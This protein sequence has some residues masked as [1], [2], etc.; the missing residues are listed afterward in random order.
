MI[1]SCPH[2]QTKY[3]VT[4]EAIGSAGRKVQCA[5]CQQAWQ[6][7]PLDPDPPSPEQKQAFEAIEEDG[8]DDALL[9]EERD[10]T[11]DLGKRKAVQPAEA[12]ARVEASEAEAALL[13]KRQ[14]DFSRRQ[15]AMVADLP[16]ARL[17]R[18]MRVVGLLLLTGLAG[19]FYF[20]RERVVERYPDMAGVY[21]A[22]GLGVNIVGLDFSN[23][24]TLLTL[25]D[26]KEVLTVSAQI[27][28]L[29]ADPVAVPPV[30]ATL[31]DASGRGI[32]EWSVTP[33]VRDLMAGERSTFDTRLTMPP[34]EASSVRLSFARG[35]SVRPGA[36]RGAET[37]RDTILE[38]E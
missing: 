8:L 32:Y 2:C 12:R 5:H 26:G 36:A 22:V 4:Y 3:Q 9:A 14:K 1:I 38:H 34:G 29:R 16:L 7:R 27:K 30:V 13:R 24:T 17:R 15:S 6:Q 31:L 10:A 20:G 37:R 21:E 33:S 23:V 18:T 35:P 28:G 25:Q 19:L 11:A